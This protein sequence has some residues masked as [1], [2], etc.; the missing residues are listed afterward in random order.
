[1]SDQ[2]QDRITQADVAKAAPAEYWKHR[3]V[4]RRE[5]RTRTA[6][7]LTGLLLAVSFGFILWAA[8]PLSAETPLRLLAAAGGATAVNVP[9]WIL[10]VV[11]GR[12]VY[13]RAA[14]EMGL[15][16]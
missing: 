9:F 14:E 13:N 1:M 2:E 8:D 4:V 6:W 11:H 12:I 15:D 7:G 10:S 3:S 5:Q 16:E